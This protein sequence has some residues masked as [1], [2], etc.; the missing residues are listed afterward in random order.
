M[1]PVRVKVA[2]ASP[3]ANP[4]STELIRPGDPG[5]PWAPQTLGPFNVA[6]RG[7]TWPD[8]QAPEKLYQPPPIQTALSKQP[9]VSQSSLSVEDPKQVPYE[10][11]RTASMKD[12]NR[13]P[14]EEESSQACKHTL[15]HA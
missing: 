7:G 14:P 12:L 10:R 4:S 15:K 1:R 3:P 8:E 2:A 6:A 11:V 9:L 5:Y 13:K